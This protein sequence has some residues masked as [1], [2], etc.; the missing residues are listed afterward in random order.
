M[1]IQIYV[2][3][4]KQCENVAI[5]D[6][7]WVPPEKKDRHPCPTPI[8]L[9]SFFGGQ[10]DDSVDAP[11]E[12]IVNTKRQRKT[13]NYAY[14]TGSAKNPPP[15][16]AGNVNSAKNASGMAKYP[17]DASTQ[18]PASITSSASNASW[19][20]LTG[21]NDDDDEYVEMS[22]ASTTAVNAGAKHLS[23]AATKPTKLSSAVLASKPAAKGA[24]KNILSSSSSIRAKVSRTRVGEYEA[25]V[26]IMPTGRLHF[27][28]GYSAQWKIAMFSG[29]I[30]NPDGSKP[31]VEQ[32]KTFR[33]RDDL[34]LKING[35]SV[36]GKPFQKILQTIRKG[37]GKRKSTSI[38]MTML[39]S[40]Y[41]ATLLGKDAKSTIQTTP[42]PSTL[43]Y[44]TREYEVV[45]PITPA[46]L[47][48]QIGEPKRLKK[49][50]FFL[51]YTANSYAEHRKPFRHVGDYIIK[52]NGMSII[53]KPFPDVL[54]MLRQIT[55]N[56]Q[57]SAAACKVVTFVAVD[58]TFDRAALPAK[59]DDWHC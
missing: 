59:D 41:V 10:I 40:K 8:D 13:V 45:L 7:G 24:S 21:D 57:G 16:P 19:V 22:T 55:V 15:S 54:E 9:G 36:I 5:Q 23:F 37:R 38:S 39:E 29:Y 27:H 58:R 35:Q 32:L 53:G 2:H 47:Q 26:P 6:Y 46:G 11:E 25:I 34:I 48:I 50:T 3:C 43:V 52:I 51:G 30:A 31:V 49:H 14:S 12:L 56:G 18:S 42:S 44:K 4:S 28:V 17:S 20:D 33:N 1:P